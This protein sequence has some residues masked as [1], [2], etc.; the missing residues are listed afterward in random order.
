MRRALTDV[1]VRAEWTG[2]MVSRWTRLLCPLLQP[3]CRQW[4]EFCTGVTK[5][6]TNFTKFW[7]CTIF[8]VSA[9]LLLFYTSATNS[10]RQEALFLGRFYSHLSISPSVHLSICPSLQLAVVHLHIFYVT[11]CM[12]TWS[13]DFNETWHKYSS[14]EWAL[15]ERFSRLEVKGQGH[16]EVRCTFSAEG[17]RWLMAFCLLPVWHWGS[18]VL[19]FFYLWVKENLL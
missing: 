10:R 17:C 3:D 19:T 6:T 12:Y 13:R 15:L 5:F 11:R 16:R 7:M 9:Q 8:T 4:Q 2:S 14:C 1:W 18:V